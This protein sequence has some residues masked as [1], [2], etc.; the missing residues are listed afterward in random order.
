MAIEIGGSKSAQ[1]KP[2]MNITPLVDIVLVLLIIFMVVTPLLT[3]QFWIQLPKIEEMKAETTPDEKNKPVVLTVKDDG[4]LELNGEPIA[5]DA[6]REKLRRVF[7]AKNGDHS[8]FFNADDK[9][10]YGAT[11]EAMDVARA[12]GAVPIS[13]LT[14]KPKG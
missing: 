11:V 9:A 7:A 3:K 5:K 2:A 12:G 6:L 1:V 10:P 14:E 13:I 4:A 8:L